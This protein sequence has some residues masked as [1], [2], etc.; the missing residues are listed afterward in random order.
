MNPFKIF[1][2]IKAQ[3]KSYIQTFQKFKNKEIEE[4]VRRQTEEGNLLWQ[5]PLLQITK[6][7]KQGKTLSSFV[8]SGLLHKECLNVFKYGDKVIHPY[9]HQDQAFTIGLEKQQSFIVTTGTASGKSLCFEVP[10]INYCLRKKDEGQKGIKAIIIYPMNALANSQYFELA[11]KLNGSKVKIGLY[12]GDTKSDQSSALQSYKD[13]FGKDAQ[14]NDSEIISRIEMQRTPPDILITNYAQLELLL[15]RLEDRG[16]FPEDSKRNLKFLVIDE[17]HTYRGKKATDVAFLIRRLKQ[18]TDTIGKLIC[19]GTSATMVSEKKGVNSDEVVAE[20]ATKF[21]GEQFLP[22]NVVKE[23]EDETLYFKGDVLNPKF[24]LIEDILSNPSGDIQNL[25]AVYR[26]LTGK[27]DLDSMSLTELGEKLKSSKTLSFIESKLSEKILSFSELVSLYQKEVRPG[28]TDHQCALELYAGFY[29]GMS[30]RITTDTGN[31]VPRFITKLHTFFNQGKELRKCLVDNCGYIS[32]NGE[33]TCPKCKQEGRG[34]VILLPLH[35]CR[36]CGQ[37]YYGVKLL[38]DHHILP[39]SMY[40]IDSSESTGYFTNQIHFIIPDE[41]PENWLTPVRHEIKNTFKEYV[42]RLVTI[43]TIDKKFSNYIP[44]EEQ[45]GVFIPYPLHLC[46]SC[47]TE[48]SGQVSEYTKMFLLNSIGRATGTNVLTAASINSTTGDEKK[49]IAFSDNRQDSAFQTGHFNDW[50]SQIFFRQALRE[51][52][53]DSQDSINIKEVPNKLFSKL[54]PKNMPRNPM[55]TRFQRQYLKYL[56]TYLYVEIRGTK[57]FTSQ[58]LEDVGLLEV[59]YDGLW[60]WINDLSS[61]ENFKILKNVNKEI[62][63]DFLVGFMDIFRL[64]VAINHNDLINKEPFRQEVISFLEANYPQ[65]RLFEAIENTKPGGFTDGESN[66]IK[67]KFNPHALSG[68]R[69]FKSW[70]QKVFGPQSDDVIFTQT[71]KF[72][73]DSGYLV[74]ISENHQD[75]TLLTSDL[76]SIK[77][78]REGFKSQCARCDS[79]Y[80]WK[81]VNYCVQLKCKDPLKEYEPNH[82]YYFNQY[83]V[84]PDS[85]NIVRAA[86][87]SAQVKGDVRKQRENDFKNNKLNLLVSTPTMELGIDIGTLSSI[88]MRNVP[89]NPSNYVQRAGRAGRSGKGSLITTFCGSGP[90]RGSHDQY[91]YNHRID[92]VSGK[93]S[94]PR[95]NLDNQKLF[96]AHVNS[97]ILQTIDKKLFTK[98]SQ[99]LNFDDLINRIPM[100]PDYKSDLDQVITSGKEIIRNCIDAAFG[101]EIQ[102]SAGE[103]NWNIIEQQTTDFPLNLDLA[104]EDLRTDYLESLKEIKELDDKIR[105]E[106]QAENSIHH[107]R[108]SALERR[109]QS[110]K[111]GEDEFYIYRYLSQSGFLPNYAFPTVTRQV[112]FLF[113]R[114]EESISREQVISLTE[115]APYNT[116]YYEGQ[117]FVVEHASGE[118]DVKNF[119]NFIICEMCGYAEKI[120]VG[121]SIPTNCV[122]C[123]ATLEN[124]HTIKALNMPRMRA[125]NRRRI[126]SDEEERVKGGYIINNSYRLTDK[127]NN[128]SLLKNEVEFATLSFERSATMFHF[129]LGF[130]SEELKGFMVDPHTNKWLIQSKLKEHFEKHPGNQNALLRELNLYVKSENDVLTFRSN[131]NHGADEESFALTL[132]Y[133]LL[134]SIAFTLNLD[135][136]E[137][138]GFVQLIPDQPSRIV[139]YELS[140]GGSGTLSAIHK[141]TSVLQKVAL[142]SLDLLHMDTDGNDLDNACIKSCYNCICTF[143]NQLKHNQLNRNLVKDFL[144]L[145]SKINAVNPKYDSTKNESIYLEYLDKCSSELEKDILKIIYELNI[146]LPDELHRTITHQ[147]TMIAEADLFYEP[148]LCVF[149][150]GP[151]HDK[152]YV[153]K[154]DIEKRSKLKALAKHVVVIR[155]DQIYSGIQELKSIVAPEL[156]EIINE[157]RIKFI[158]LK[159]NWKEKKKLISSTT[160]IN[161]IASYQEI[162]E[163]GNDVLPFIISELKKE[164]D[165]WFEALAQLT[166]VNPIKDENLGKVEL[167]SKDWIEWYEQK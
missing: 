93:I 12:T 105:N 91:F 107:L 80:N 77:L 2:D 51:V 62:L 94:M 64:E 132:L 144:L 5:E 42:P 15:T 10:I 60:D 154:D 108:R 11:K 96:L 152:D 20:F 156:N 139:I 50:Y 166:G 9:F 17:L 83:T 95:F 89:P 78:P 32:I 30:C 135:E 140:E 23:T 4:F 157:T 86:D 37:E 100:F 72:L 34:E 103:L 16:L 79:K 71:L 81:S 90:G 159:N 14:P 151:D 150:D 167:M 74:T 40:D 129:N 75:V 122:S 141:E 56:E 134:Q 109:N 63:Y 82:N 48:H 76:I 41:L 21:F 35:F 143:Y 142:K 13:I 104:F 6:K 155:Y 55:F 61:L 7:F 45:E 99:I 112:R 65:H 110:I 97:L 26:C 85:G 24:E 163:I 22:E 66:S 67:Y 148:R 161:E 88:Y 69:R 43:D 123:G 36:V 149:I 92:M 127:A 165:F 120:R 121:Q 102:N 53:S 73:T 68:S 3:Y 130:R 118:T 133:T 125:L 146:K 1:D 113:E 44:D 98:A 115:F 136:S 106:N 52:L 33:T 31:E 18:R 145:L 58:N 119:E 49:V 84:N 162:I 57:K 59:V 114:N 128:F 131:Q 70:I 117:K 116:L 160:Q 158:L 29:L 19:I 147:N 38:P 27:N 54:V 47:G 124:T 164:P 126:T 46:I 138:N 25:F 28:F 39:W 101:T 87:H 137:I 111:D 153:I 8:N